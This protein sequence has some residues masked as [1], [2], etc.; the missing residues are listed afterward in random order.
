MGFAGREE[1]TGELIWHSTAAAGIMARWVPS[2]RP[3]V[4]PLVSLLLSNNQY[5]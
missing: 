5:P 2:A 3:S 1:E 4:F